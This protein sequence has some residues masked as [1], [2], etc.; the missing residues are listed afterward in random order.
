MRLS[1]AIRLGAMLMPQAFG[2][3][4]MEQ[5]GVRSSCAIGAAT[6]ALGLSTATGGIYKEFPYLTVILEQRCHLCHFT[7]LYPLEM[8]SHLNDYHRWTR[9]RIADWVALNE[10]CASA[11]S[12]GAVDPVGERDVDSLSTAWS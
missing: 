5:H 4:H 12:A 9:E 8:V 2:A 7:A 10:P 1:E 3:M 6:D 11:T